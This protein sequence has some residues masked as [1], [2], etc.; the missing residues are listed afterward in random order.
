MTEVLPISSLLRCFQEVKMKSKKRFNP[1]ELTAV[2]LLAIG[3]LVAVTIPP[4]EGR[5]TEAKWLGAN[6]S[7]RAIQ[8]AVNNY[9]AKTDIAAAKALAGKNLNDQVIRDALDLTVTDLEGVYFTIS[10]YSITS[11]DST[12]TATITVAAS[13]ADVPSGS[14]RLEEDGDWVRL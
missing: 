7:A 12:G 5:V 11:V 1:A 2:I 14:Y 8:R 13:K 6:A 3:I 4:M 9:A 10:D